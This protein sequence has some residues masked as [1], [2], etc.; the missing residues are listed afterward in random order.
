M[1]DFYRQYIRTG[2]IGLEVGL[3]II[4]GAGLGDWIDGHYGVAPAGIFIGTAFGVAAAGKALWR[5]SKDYLRQ[6][7]DD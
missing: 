7:S 1:D 5:L 6:N 3:S 2:A 4:V